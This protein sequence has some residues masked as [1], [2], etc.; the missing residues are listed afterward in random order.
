MEAAKEN[1]LVFNRTR[2]N[3][4]TKFIKFFGALYD[5]NGMHSDSH[6]IEV[7]KALKSPA[8]EAELQY[9]LRMVK[10]GPIH[11][12]TMRAHSYSV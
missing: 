12:T 6:K 9:I 10:Y 7:I 8:N 3:I 2:C 4:K 11:T 1:D 5:K